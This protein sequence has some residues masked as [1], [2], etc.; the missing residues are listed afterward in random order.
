MRRRKTRIV[1][2]VTQQGSRGWGVQWRRGNAHRDTYELVYRGQ[3]VGGVVV[4][5]EGWKWYRTEMRGLRFGHRYS[6][7]TFP[8]WQ[9]AVTAFAKRYRRTDRGRGANLPDT[10]VNLALP[11]QPWIPRPIHSDFT[12]YFS[13]KE[14]T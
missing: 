7:E 8:T 3:Y 12:S 9:D 1:L 2:P 11:R 6:G 14:T 10:W 4:T 13:V 5:G